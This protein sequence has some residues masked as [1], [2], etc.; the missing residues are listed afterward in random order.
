MAR[1]IEVYGHDVTELI[2]G[3][4]YNFTI[5]YPEDVFQRN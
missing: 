2:I 5:G 1:Y 4:L 3:Y